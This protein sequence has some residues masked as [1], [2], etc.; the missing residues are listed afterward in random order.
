MADATNDLLH[1]LLKSFHVRMDKLDRGLADL[2]SE[3]ITMRGNIVTIQQDVHHIYSRLDRVDQRLDRI[4]NR[5]ELR[6]LAEAQARF[7]PHP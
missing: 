7:E 4:E 5:L 1:E 2:R 3:M 6:E